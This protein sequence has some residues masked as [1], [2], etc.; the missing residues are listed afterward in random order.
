MGSPILGD[1]CK[2]VIRQ[3]EEKILSLHLPSILLYKRY[4][5]DILILWNVKP[6]VSAFLDLV[7]DNQYGLT[8]KLDQAHDTQ[9]YFLDISIGVDGMMICTEVYRKLDSETLY[10]PIGSCDPFH[11]KMAAFNTLI[12]RAYTHS[13][14]MHALETELKIISRIAERHGYHNHITSLSRK[15]HHLQVAAQTTS[16][17]KGRPDPK[18]SIPIT[19]NP[20]LQ[21][22]FSEIA[23]KKCISIAYRRC[24]SVFALLHN[25]K[26]RYSQPGRAIWSIYHPA[27]RSY[28]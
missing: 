21:K 6:D 7:N 14:T 13:S 20:F 22:L 11:Y 10:I 3:L 15:L 18:D 9:V 4:V 8:L 19:Y 28:V 5:D 17:G 25:A 16:H 12:K 1:L 23:R 2:L 26:E 24:P 27:K